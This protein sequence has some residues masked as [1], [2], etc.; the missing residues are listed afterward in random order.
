MPPPRE[1]WAAAFAAQAQSDWQVCHLLSKQSDLPACHRLHYLQMACE[2]I[3]KAYRCRD[4]SAKLDQLL[5]RHVGFAKF[6]SSFLLSPAMRQ[7]Y[8]DKAAQLRQV[9]KGVLAIAREVEKLAPAVDGTDSPENAE[10]PWA[11]GDAVVVPCEYDYPALSLLREPQGRT[12]L[13]LMNRALRDFGP[14]KI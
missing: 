2:K 14:V 7:Q 10:Y 3:A 8:R 12:F 4:T 13:K 9:R 6:M 5:T 11:N 1:A